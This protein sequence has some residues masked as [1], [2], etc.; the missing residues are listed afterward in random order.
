MAI[1]SSKELWEDRES[2]GDWQYNRTHT[3]SWR[4]E[5][6]DRDDDGFVVFVDG[7][8]A[9]PD[10]LPVVYEPHPTDPQSF[11]KS[12]TCRPDSGSAGKTWIVTVTYDNKVEL[13]QG[14]DGA[15]E[16]DPTLRAPK[17]SWSGAKFSKRVNK[18]RD[19]NAVLNSARQPF[20]PPPERDMSRRVL[21][22]T[23]IEADYDD[24]VAE[25]Y[26]DAV[27]S[28]TFYGRAPGKAKMDSITAHRHYENG[29]KYWEV[30][31]VIHFSKDGWQLEGLDIG[32]KYMD[33]DGAIWPTDGNV[34]KLLDGEGGLLADDE[35]AVYLP[36]DVYP[37]MA[38][39]SLNLE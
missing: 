12:A 20:D 30:T 11:A 14:G 17:V 13:D 4:V 22:I 33:A 34:K 16:T 18:D 28:D 24:S 3:R 38:F 37:E 7:T 15:P 6:N 29:T 27:N 31:Y 2:T 9:T 25:D 8:D 26:E 23:R 36:F 21:T 10:P 32:N 5:T 19:G 35:D 39:A 1:L